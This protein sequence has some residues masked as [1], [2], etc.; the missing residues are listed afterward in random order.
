MDILL[1][2]LSLTESCFS[3]LSSDHSGHKRSSS[4]GRTYSFTS[5]VSR[6]CIL[7]DEDKNVKAG[8]QAALQVWCLER[9]QGCNLHNHV[10]HTTNYSI[11]HK[12]NNYQQL[13]VF[14]RYNLDFICN[15]LKINIKPCDH[16]L[17]PD[18]CFKTDSSFSFLLWVLGIN[19]NC[20]FA[21]LEPHLLEILVVPQAHNARK[22]VAG[23]MVLLPDQIEGMP[24]KPILCNARLCWVWNATWLFTRMM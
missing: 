5:A 22:W 4:W 24:T 7:E 13:I 21:F 2:A 12:E 10:T 11:V 3:K 8:A 15:F 19:Q 18:T 14:V 17:E 20:T 23:W 16:V 1:S 9:E 6:G